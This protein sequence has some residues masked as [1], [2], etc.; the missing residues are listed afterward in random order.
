[1]TQPIALGFGN[2]IDY[3]L[4]WDSQIINDLVAEYDIREEELQADI[5]IS[6]VRELLISI[7][8]FLLESAGGERRVICPRVI[9][10]FA[11]RFPFR[12]TL[13]GT[14]VRAALAMNKLGYNAAL[15]LVTMNDDVRA[16]LPPDCR[17]VCSNTQDSVY[18]HLIVQFPEGTRVH[19]E[20]RTFRT[21]RANRIIYV[22]DPDNTEMKIN[23]LFDSFVAEAGLVLISGFNAM[24]DSAL[25][26]DRVQ[27]IDHMLQSAKKQAVVVYEDACFHDPALSRQLIVTLGAHIDIHSMNEDEV[28]AWIGRQVDCLD[29]EDV[30]SALNDL[31]SLIQAPVVVVHSRTWALAY[32]DRADRFAAALKSGITMAATRHRIGDDFTAE[33][34][35]RTTCCAFSA[36]GM[37]FA[38]RL[39]ALG[40]QMICCLPCFDFEEKSTTTVGLGDAFIG[41]FLPVLA[42]EYVD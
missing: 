12:V 9:P 32:G 38:D 34:C 41:G 13:G 1:V 18:P 5:S 11:S 40:K 23:R 7:L 39:N 21:T 15:H 6:N 33:D 27:T 10:E 16:L 28:Q 26:S 37:R 17:W 35:R 3:E 42:E 20:E 30:F 2:N 22:F 14:A 29:A 24:S 19:C 8:V 36:D 4:A 31:E 25:L